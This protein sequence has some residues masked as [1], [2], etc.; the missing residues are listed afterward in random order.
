MQSCVPQPVHTEQR[1]VHLHY[2]T[3]ILNGQEERTVI[4][5]LRA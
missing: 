3:V 2:A 5:S 1:H 4:D